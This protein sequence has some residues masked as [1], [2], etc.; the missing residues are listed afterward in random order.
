[1]V[2]VLGAAGVLYVLFVI[3]ERFAAE[4]MLLLGLFRNQVFE[5]SSLLSLL[6]LM[7]LVGMW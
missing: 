2:G 4:P 1:V 3:A 7:V 5:A 6:Q